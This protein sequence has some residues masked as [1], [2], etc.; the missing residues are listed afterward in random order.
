M[1]Q[2]IKRNI[3]RR[4]GL[5]VVFTTG[6]VGILASGSGGDNGGVG[7]RCALLV[8]AIAPAKDGSNDIWIGLRI[9][10][11]LDEV[12]SV[13]RLN[14]EGLEEI[15]VRVASGDPGHGTKI[16]T[17]EIATDGSNDVYIGGDFNEGI[18]RLNGDGSRDTGFSVGSGFNG[19]VSQITAATDGSGDIYVG[20]YFSEYNGTAV[21]GLVRLHSDGSLDSAG[22]SAVGASQ[23]NSVELAADFFFLGD[24]YTAS[25][26]D[27]IDRW[28]S[29]G[30]QDSTSF[31]EWQ[32]FLS[33]YPTADITGDIYA[34]GYTSAGVIRLNNNGT[35]DNEFSTGS[36]FSWASLNPPEII[37]LG[38]RDMTGDVYV[39][40]VFT[41]YNGT[42]ANGIIRLNDDGS[43]DPNF[44]IGDGFTNPTNEPELDPGVWTAT[45]VADMT[46]DIYVG[47]SFTFYD[48]IPSSGVVRLNSDGSRDMGFAVN[49][50]SSVGPCTDENYRIY[51]P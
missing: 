48:G 3:L 50:S 21:S 31:P 39:G 38:A 6:I 26:D 25:N 24:I 41:T 49:I 47:G 32:G 18:L 43:R 35:I 13:V 15:N 51:E 10:N 16:R 20:G 22:F 14:S 11:Y 17:I 28:Q 8:R 19:R 40:G 29:D 44:I 23:I 37:V 45:L 36:G 12:D 42:P 2:F 4:L 30:T 5:A 33:I 46:G 9:R 34:A 7:D 27:G 1:V